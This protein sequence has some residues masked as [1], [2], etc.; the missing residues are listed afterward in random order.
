MTCKPL[1]RYGWIELLLAL[2]C[3]S[4]ASAAGCS[5][6]AETAPMMSVASAQPSGTGGM[7]GNSGG[8]GAAAPAA[9]GANGAGEAPGLGAGLANMGAMTGGAGSTGMLCNAAGDADGDGTNDCLDACPEDPNKLEAGACGCGMRDSDIDFDGA[10]D[11]QEMCPGDP[12]KT[13]PGACGCGLAD[14]DTD[15]D[16]TLDC[17]DD[18]PRDGDRTTPGTCGCGAADALPLCLRHRY[19]FNGMGAVATDSVGDADGEITGGATLAGN[20]TL[21]LAGLATDQY[22]DL[23]NGIISELGSN[24]T[25]EAWVSWTGAGAP[26]QRIF[27]FGS[28]ELAEGQQGTGVTYLFLTP[29]NTINTDLRVAYTNVGPPAERVV[30]APTPLPFPA[31]VHVAV[32]IDGA[33]A[34][35]ALYQ[36]GNL[37]GTTPTL[38]TT[39]ALMNDVNNWIGRS[40]F[41]ADEEFQGTLDEF[42]IYSSARNAMQIALDTAA[43]PNAL[44]AN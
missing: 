34:T 35:L 43:G 26:W 38:D 14:V 23:P 32:V 25:I 42:R 9:S 22:V 12:G 40:Q 27:D 36:N 37:I 41:V 1:N 39:L 10:L 31:Q 30:N 5:D 19:S 2:C 8:P 15:M 16:G 4:A 7:P 28:S 13:M 18:C 29:S 21:V 17:D 6:E 44:P 3:A 11:C 24:A 20:G 33:A